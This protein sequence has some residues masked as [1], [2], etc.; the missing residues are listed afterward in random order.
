MKN[1]MSFFVLTTLLFF[2]SCSKD[3]LIQPETAAAAD[4]ETVNSMV[5]KSDTPMSL[6]TPSHSRNNG[7]NVTVSS[8]SSD[9]VDL[10]I[11]FTSAHD[12]TDRDLASTQTIDFTD[13][14][15][16]TVSLTFG[17]NSYSGGNGTLDVNLA[18]GGND[19]TGLGMKTAQ[20]I[21]EDDVM[22]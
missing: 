5:Q 19:L 9:G 16:N 11:D 6:G 20:I 14:N 17:V 18:I 1:L 2:A 3:A 7:I 13:G 8:Q 12:F 4:V 10:M 15:G 21:V 22:N